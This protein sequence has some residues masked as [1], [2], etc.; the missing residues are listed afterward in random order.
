MKIKWRENP[1][2]SIRNKKN[3]YK[4]ISKNKKMKKIQTKENVPLLVPEF[5]RGQKIYVPDEIWEK[6]GRKNFMGGLA[7]I[8][9]LDTVSPL[10]RFGIKE[11]PGPRTYEWEYMLKN[12]EIWAKE[13]AGKKAHVASDWSYEVN[14]TPISG[15]KIYVGSSLHMDHG[16]DDFAGG[17]ATVYQIKYNEDLPKDHCNYTF[18]SIIEEPGSDYNWRGLLEKQKKLS[19]QYAGQ[20]AHPDPD[21]REE[22]NKGW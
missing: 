4:Q 22:F 14:K 10:I 7:T 20:I 21:Y 6:A 5:R 9:I 12:Q 19:K 1:Y 16:K 17:L 15:E 11:R 18:V 3:I 2:I 13:Y 8:S